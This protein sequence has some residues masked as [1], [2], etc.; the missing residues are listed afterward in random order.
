MAIRV[1]SAAL[2]SAVLFTARADAV[3]V[4]NRDGGDHRVTVIEGEARKDHVVKA[5]ES[6]TGVCLSGCLMRL[7]D[8][9]D[10]PYELEGQE[11]TWIEGG[12]L[13]EEQSD[14]PQDTDGGD[15]DPSSRPSPAPVLP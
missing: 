6:L 8:S 3:T 15:A 11:I 10:E 13:L 9:S 14:G 4:S 7:D 12:E 5:G 1:F 2:I